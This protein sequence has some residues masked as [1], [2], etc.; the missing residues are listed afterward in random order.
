MSGREGQT[1]NQSRLT[2]K[3]FFS[4][5]TLEVFVNIMKMTEKDVSILE[6]GDN[7]SSIKPVKNT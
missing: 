6:I 2:K 4:K 1:C 3:S 5:V 7:G